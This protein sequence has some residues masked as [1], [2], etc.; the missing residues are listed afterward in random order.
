MLNVRYYFSEDRVIVGEANPTVKTTGRSY[1]FQATETALT[2]SLVDLELQERHLEGIE[3][4]KC[5]ENQMLVV[6]D[7]DEVAFAMYLLPKDQA[8]RCHE[9]LMPRLV[10]FRDALKR[11]VTIDKRHVQYM[12][13]RQVEIDEWKAEKAVEEAAEKEA[14]EARKKARREARAIEREADA[15]VDEERKKERDEYLAKL[16]ADH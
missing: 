9:H 13:G 2:K 6:M 11:N 16:E 3:R 10:G 12:A 14:A 8:E 1:V 4:F 7:G 5:S 15:K